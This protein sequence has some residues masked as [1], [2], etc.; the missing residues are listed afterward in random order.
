LR[1]RIRTHHLK[2]P[3]VTPAGI[4]PREK[5]KAKGRA[6][7]KERE[8]E[9]GSMAHKEKVL[10]GEVKVFKNNDRPKVPLVRN[11]GGSVTSP[12]IAKRASHALIVANQDITQGIVGH[13]PVPGLVPSS[14]GPSRTNTRGA[15]VVREGTRAATL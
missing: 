8:K 13:L 4:N 5:E 7:E 10:G 14:L 12:P 1:G 9:K 11:V 15:A 2:R 6:K 3:N